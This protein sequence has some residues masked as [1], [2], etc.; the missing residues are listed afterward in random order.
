MFGEWAK[1]DALWKFSIPELLSNN[2]MT[3]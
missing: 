1:Q 3:M 2:V